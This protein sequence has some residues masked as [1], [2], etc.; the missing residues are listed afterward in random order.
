MEQL[1]EFATNHWM[2]T[3]SFLGLLVLLILHESGNNGV[4]STQATEMINKQDAVIVD[5][6]DRNDF[7]KGSLTGAV[8]I[9]LTQLDQ[10]M[11]ELKA[12][13]EKPVIVVCRMGSSASL[14]VQKLHKQGYKQAV[15]LKGGIMQWQ[16]DGLPL[17]AS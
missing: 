9:P 13:Q 7:K 11:D 1:L 17:V 14:A 3:L 2:L 10:R 15:R 5:I 16:S 8:N 6:R 4:S 12:Y